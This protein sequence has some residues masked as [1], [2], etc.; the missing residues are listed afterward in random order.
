MQNNQRV[1]QRI[2]YL[3]KY[4]DNIYKGKVTLNDII[5][6]L[7]ALVTEKGDKK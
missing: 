4:G 7:E 1:T 6:E 3:K 5:K 2:E